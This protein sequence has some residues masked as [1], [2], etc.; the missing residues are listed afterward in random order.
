ME[1]VT[2]A[3]GNGGLFGFAVD[4]ARRS[5]TVR[6]NTS[7]FREGAS[8][9]LRDVECR[10]EGL[11]YLALAIAPDMCFSDELVV[12]AFSEGPPG[13]IIELERLGRF[14]VLR[15]GGLAGQVAVGDTAA[16]GFHL[17]SA[18]AIEALWICSNASFQ[19]GPPSSRP[20]L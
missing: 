20:T 2:E 17:S 9:T 12:D 5:L 7:M 3:G 11:V 14:V 8:I 13:E 6:L 10:F 4:V 19:Q 16:L 1:P 15:P 18:S